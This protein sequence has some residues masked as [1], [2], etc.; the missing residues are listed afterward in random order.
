MQ[1]FLMAE[2]FTFS[3]FD[4][5]FSPCRLLRCLRLSEIQRYWAMQ[6][7]LVFSTMN[8][9]QLCL[10]IHLIKFGWFLFRHVYLSWRARSSL[11]T[12]HTSISPSK[13]SRCDPGTTLLLHLYFYCVQFWSRQTWVSATSTKKIILN[14]IHQNSFKTFNFGVGGVKE[15]C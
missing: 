9:T 6:S 8:L 15:L 5:A 12:L 1:G 11:S 3:R 10:E 13:P 2:K 14:C 7:C 4:R